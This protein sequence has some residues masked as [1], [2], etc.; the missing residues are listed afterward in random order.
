MEIS[1][2][3]F[4]DN[5][6]VGLASKAGGEEFL[7]IKGCRIVNGSNGPFISYPAKKQDTGK[8]WNHVWASEKFNSAVLAKAQAGQPSSKPA[9]RLEEEDSD[10]PF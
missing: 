1:V 9:K 10:I 3:W 7:S 6:N 5:F 8:Y 2:K 4:G